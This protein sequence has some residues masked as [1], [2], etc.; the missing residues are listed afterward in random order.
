M[1]LKKQ[2]S[3]TFAVVVPLLPSMFDIFQCI[4]KGLDS[5]LCVFFI[6]LIW[7]STQVQIAVR[8]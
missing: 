3:N 4:F 8:G 1:G 7:A 6:L 5:G 2:P